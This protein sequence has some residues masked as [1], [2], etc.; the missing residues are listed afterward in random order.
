[1]ELGDQLCDEK[2]ERAQGAG[3]DGLNDQY[4]RVLNRERKRVNFH[5]ENV[6]IIS[7]AQSKNSQTA[8][9]EILENQDFNLIVFVYLQHLKLV[10]SSVFIFCFGH[11]VT[12][13]IVGF[14]FLKLGIVMRFL[15]T[16]KKG[17]V[18]RKPHIYASFEIV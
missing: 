11:R 2:R 17:Q 15:N 12:N 4:Y 7:S 18:I 9:T 5:L 16:T 3:D 14:Y 10:A 13:V 1:M 8:K 6:A